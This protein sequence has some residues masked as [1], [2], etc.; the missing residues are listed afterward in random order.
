MTTYESHLK[1][2]TFEFKFICKGVEIKAEVDSNVKWHDFCRACIKYG[3]GKYYFDLPEIIKKG[4]ASNPGNIAIMLD[5]W[6]W[7]EA[8]GTKRID[9]GISRV[10]WEAYNGGLVIWMKRIKE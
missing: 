2:T 10:L 9:N 5:I 4:I 1:I 8:F 3:E 6:K 7:I